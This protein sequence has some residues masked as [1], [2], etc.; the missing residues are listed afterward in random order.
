MKNEGAFERS[1]E[2][3]QAVRVARTHLEELGFSIELRRIGTDLLSTLCSVTPT[4]GSAVASSGKGVGEQSLASALFES[5]EHVH[6][7]RDQQRP[8]DEARLLDLDGTD[9]PLRDGTPDFNF[10]AGDHPLWLSRLEMKPLSAAEADSISFPRFLQQPSFV[11]TDP[12]EEDALAR[13]SLRRYGTNSGTAAGSTRAEALLHGL[14]EIIERDALGIE[15]LRS[16][17][18]QKPVPLR[19]LE[20]RDCAMIGDLEEELRLADGLVG[21][22]AWDVTTD[23]RVPVILARLSIEGIGGFFGSGASLKVANAVQ[24]ATLEALQHLHAWQAGEI[25]PPSSGGLFW[26]PWLSRCVL[27]RGV[28]SPQGGEVR[29]LP[30]PDIEV[31]APEEQLAGTLALLRQ[32]KVEVY[33]RTLHSSSVWVTQVAAPRLERFHL[34]SY[35]VPVSP[36]NRG[37]KV[38]KTLATD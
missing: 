14:L 34:A 2:V 7:L 29:S 8:A 37:R 13:F 4:E 6:T 3:A 30:P 17:F 18:A 10:V 16:C 26:P 24:R 36:G 38:L 1:L 32:V 31:G 28:F 12:R 35:G 21:L 23:T 19:R 27:R 9:L 11:P 25:P 5:I 15:L 20:G 33:E 22:T